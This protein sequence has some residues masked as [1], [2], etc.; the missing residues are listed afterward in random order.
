MAGVKALERLLADRP[1]GFVH[2]TQVASHR[3]LVQ[4]VRQAAALCRAAGVPLWVD[5][6]KALGHVDTACGADVVYATS[7]KWL[8]GPRGVGVLAV[9]ARWWDRLRPEACPLARPV[10]ADGDAG[11]G[12]KRNPGGN[13]GTGGY[14]GP[15]RLLEPAEAN[16]AGR[17]GLCAAVRRHVDAGPSD[18]WRRLAEVGIA[19]REILGGLPGWEVLRNFS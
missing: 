16:M 11:P 17:V 7:R 13:D 18:V 6:A 12:G 2:L 10:P 4:P 15:V 5:A 9:A 3:P 14:A 1:P 8:A 19:T